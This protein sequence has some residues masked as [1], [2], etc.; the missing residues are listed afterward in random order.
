MVRH[1]R[2]PPDT[3]SAAA[4]LRRLGFALCKPDPGTKSP[5]DEGWST[6]TLEADDFAEGDL[7][8]IL[9]G[10]LSDGNRTGHAATVVEIDSPDALNVAGR[11]LPVT[12]MI[13]GRPGKPRSHLYYLLPCDSIPDWAQSYAEQGAPAALEQKGHRGPFT[14]SFRHERTRGEVLR[15]VGTGG[16]VVAP[17]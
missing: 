3:T 14:K 17:P 15:L 1:G 12:G 7:L 8:G 13:D 10:P 4:R 2:E 16:Q 6:R 11:H 9:G 5:S